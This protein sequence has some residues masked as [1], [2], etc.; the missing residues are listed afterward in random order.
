[1]RYQTNIA[2]LGKLFERIE[3]AWLD[4]RDRTIIYA[5]SEQHPEFCEQIL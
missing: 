5:L 2:L 1:M 3:R 4:N